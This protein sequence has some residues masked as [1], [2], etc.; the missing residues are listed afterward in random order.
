MEGQGPGFRYLESGGLGVR[1][2]C[3]EA[4][5]AVAILV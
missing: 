1:V 3:F 4:L 2:A 5:Q